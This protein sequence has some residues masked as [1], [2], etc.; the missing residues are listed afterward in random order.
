M[1]N[2]QLVCLNVQCLHKVADSNSLWSNRKTVES[3]ASIFIFF[4]CSFCSVLLIILR[5]K[6]KEQ[7][8]SEMVFYNIE[9]FQIVFDAFYG[10]F[11]VAR[12]VIFGIVLD[13]EK[14]SV[15]LRN[16]T[17]VTI[18]LVCNLIFLPLVSWS[19]LIIF[20]IRILVLNG[21]FNWKLSWLR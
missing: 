13:V 5:I 6:V 16:L 14:A 4:I 3:G 15:F 21:F 2:I 10:I 12:A 11:G 1:K 17:A 8:E 7:E 18:A 20:C 9:S 19:N